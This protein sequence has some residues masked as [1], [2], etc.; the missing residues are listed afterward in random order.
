MESSGLNQSLGFATGICKTDGWMSRH[1]CA[2]TVLADGDRLPLL[3]TEAAEV[4]RADDSP[5]GIKCCNKL[6]FGA[7]ALVTKWL[8]P[9][10]V[11]APTS[12]Q[13]TR[14]LA[15]SMA[16]PTLLSVRRHR[17]ENPPKCCNTV[18]NEKIPRSPKQVTCSQNADW[19]KSVAATVGC[20]I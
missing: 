17:R 2:Q 3:A 8:N 1:W 4:A 15:V 14:N 5:G 19:I 18:L 20:P 6:C 7:S 12:W 9:L 10:E 13:V 16:L 11:S